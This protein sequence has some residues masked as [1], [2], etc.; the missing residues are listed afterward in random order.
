[1]KKTTTD[2]PDI[3]KNQKDDINKHRR[4]AE[5]ISGLRNT[6]KSTLERGENTLNPQIFGKRVYITG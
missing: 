3:D 1:M 4:G 6:A 2:R 5:R